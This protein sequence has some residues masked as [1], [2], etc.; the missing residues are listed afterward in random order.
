[1]FSHKDEEEK[2]P[3][4]LGGALRHVS[5]WVTSSFHEIEYPNP[6]YQ[7]ASS[8]QDSVDDFICV[9]NNISKENEIT[10]YCIHG[11]ADRPAAFTLVA[12]RLLNNLPDRI[13]RIHL[14][15]FEDRGRGLGIDDFAQQLAEKIKEKKDKNIILMGHSRGGLVASYFAEY[16]ANEMDINVLGVVGICSP[17]GG[18]DKAIAP[19]TWVSKSVK[20]MQKGSEFLK[21]LVDKIRESNFNY[22]Y[23]A[24]KDDSLVDIDSCCIE[25]HRDAL[26]VLDTA[27]W[28]LSALTSHQLIEYIQEYV[29]DIAD[30]F[31]LEKVPFLKLASQNLF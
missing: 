24:V 29:A 31:E 13:N 20:Q 3:F 15:A 8:E 30:E 25:E 2:Q 18:S 19:L 7:P 26:T 17:F 21:E 28:H 16:L 5:L 12:E 11:T 1:M 10:I 6:N 4:V 23:F 14:A 22:R 9:N 27:H